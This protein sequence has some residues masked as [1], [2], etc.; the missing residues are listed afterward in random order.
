M[1]ESRLMINPEIFMRRENFAFSWSWHAP[2]TKAASPLP[3]SLR[4][5]FD[6]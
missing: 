1:V 2:D 3:D 5:F 4:Y 6:P